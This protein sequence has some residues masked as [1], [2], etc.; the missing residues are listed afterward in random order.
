MKLYFNDIQKNFWLNG[1]KTVSFA[2][3]I[4]GSTQQFLI[5]CV[6]WRW[7]HLSI[8]MPRKKKIRHCKW[9]TAHILRSKI[10][11]IPQ[12]ISLCRIRIN[13]F[14]WWWGILYYTTVLWNYHRCPWCYVTYYNR[15][16]WYLYTLTWYS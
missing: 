10:N 14:L 9:P 2:W 16:I 1:D 7:W 3:L 13:I 12:E 6:L 4:E 5:I 11:G 8:S 15:I